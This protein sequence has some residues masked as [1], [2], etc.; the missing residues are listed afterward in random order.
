MKEAGQGSC[1]N[2]SACVEP[3]HILS[4]CFCP[5]FFC[6]GQVIFIYVSMLEASLLSRISPWS[7]QLRFSTQSTHDTG[8]KILPYFPSPTRT[9]MSYLKCSLTPNPHP[10]NTSTV[11]LQVTT[12]KHVS[13][14]SCSQ[15]HWG[16]SMC[17]RTFGQLAQHRFSRLLP[18]SESSL[19]SFLRILGHHSR[20]G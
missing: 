15:P 3:A 12:Q 19:L 2:K 5:L 14:S 16:P 4:W 9:W 11:A 20:S 7:C 18:L 17:P 8:C 13:Q 6:R 1:D 10:K